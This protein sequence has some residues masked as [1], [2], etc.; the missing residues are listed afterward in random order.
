MSS[1]SAQ[2]KKEVL[3]RLQAFNWSGIQGKVTGNITRNCKSFVGRDFKAWMQVAVFI[4][5]HY[6]SKFI[7]K[8]LCISMWYENM[9]CIPYSGKFSREKIFANRLFAKILSANVLFS[10]D[11]DRAIALI[12]ENIIREMLYLAHSRNFLPLKIS[13]YTVYSYDSIV[14]LTVITGIPDHLCITIAF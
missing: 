11:K 12:R 13:R 3:A 4:V 10:V 8:S 1:L 7:H 6:L 9:Q 2:N 14:L 5:H